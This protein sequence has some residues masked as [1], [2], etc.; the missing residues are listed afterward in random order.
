MVAGTGPHG[1]R[2]R[3]DGENDH[4]H[5]LPY[6]HQPRGLFSQALSASLLRSGPG[7]RP[8][9]GRYVRRRVQDG[10]VLPELGQP[11][12]AGRRGAPDGE[13]RRRLAGPG[14][15]GPAI[16][17]PGCGGRPLGG[18]GLHVSGR[19][20]LCRRIQPPNAGALHLLRLQQVGHD[21][22]HG[23]GGAADRPGAEPG[24][25]L[26]AAVR[27]IPHHP[28]GAAGGQR[29]GGGHQ[30]FDSHRPPMP[31]HGLRP[32]LQR[33]GAQ[34]GLPV[35][36]LPFHGGGPGSGRTVQRG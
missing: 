15:R 32:A 1:A 3:P 27:P 14:G 25:A 17:S 24:L 2:D 4:R 11:F 36:R 18:P 26:P 28:A 10:P 31:P 35:S 7:E 16:L 22:G 8:G 6:G 20:P 13:K 19:R 5:P 33:P 29:G 30:P 9:R 12:A 21:G 34:L 23:G